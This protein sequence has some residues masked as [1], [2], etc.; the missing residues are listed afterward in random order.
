MADDTYS[1][2]YRNDRHDRGGAGDSG[3]APDPL[4]ELAR[5]IGQSDP[6]APDRNRQPDQHPT[7]YHQPY[8]TG[9]HDDRYGAAAEPQHYADTTYGSA[10]GYADQNGYAY[11]HAAQHEAQYGDT[12]GYGEPQ[13]Y[14][15]DQQAYQPGQQAYQHDEHAYY[16]DPRAAQHDERAHHHDQQGS[17]HDEQAYHQ[18]RQDY[19]QDQPPY[20]P[21]EPPHFGRA[22]VAPEPS[23]QADRDDPAMLHPDQHGGYPV[24]PFFGDPNYDEAPAPRRGWFVTA[25]ALV[26]LAVVGTAGAFAYRAVF[27]G[28]ETRIITR[29]I[30]PSK[31]TPV[32]PGQDSASKPSDRLASVGQ[33]ER[34]GPAPEQPIAIPEP[35]RTVPPALGQSLPPAPTPAPVLPAPPSA[36]SPPM[37]PAGPPARVVRTERIKPAD[38]PADATA[39]RPAGPARAGAPP[40]AVQPPPPRVAAQTPNAPLSLAP[41]SAPN[42]TAPAP[43]S[44]SHT[45]ALASTGPAADRSGAGA[46]GWYVQLSAQKSE[47]EAKSSFRGIQARHSSLLGG[48]Q[49]HIRRKDLGSKGTFYGA[50]V[51]PFSREAAGKLCDDLKAAGQPCMLQRN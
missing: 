39:P 30:G 31:I 5:L 1:R 34:L 15:Q 45:T 26:G 32:Q 4:T 3:P 10:E 49:L 11:P 9:A 46:S 29:D 41:Q 43:A 36:A 28:S 14:H 12:S 21:S 37:D 6:F 48:Q 20:A 7:E 13:P 38:Q 27:T 40:P 8:D 22:R 42:T 47:E 51:G 2:G 24:P 50:Q 23:E 16:H 35:P 25:A 18:D 17:Q 19:H 33:N 44:P